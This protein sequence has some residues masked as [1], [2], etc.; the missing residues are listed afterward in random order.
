MGTLTNEKR[1]PDSRIP[2]VVF[3]TSEYIRKYRKVK[4]F[5]GAGGGRSSD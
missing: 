1:E 5:L 3:Y 2:N 4:R